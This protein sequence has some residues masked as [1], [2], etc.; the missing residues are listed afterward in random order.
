MFSGLRGVYELDSINATKKKPTLNSIE[1]HLE[2]IE[3]QLQYD[4]DS[5]DLDLILIDRVSD[6]ERQF[7]LKSTQENGHQIFATSIYDPSIMTIG[8][9]WDLYVFHPSTEKR[10]RVRSLDQYIELQAIGIN[11][12]I[13]VVP[14]TTNKGNLSLKIQE[15]EVVTRVEEIRMDEDG[16]MTILG[17][18]MYPDKD[19]TLKDLRLNIQHP[20]EEIK[21]KLQ[22]G[23]R[24]DLTK[25]TQN[26]YQVLGF[27]THIDLNEMESLFHVA[28]ES[29]FK[30][31]YSAL[32]DK[33]E[34]FTGDTLLKLM[35]YQT[36]QSRGIIIKRPNGKQRV[37]L[38]V[39]KKTRNIRIN[40]ASYA[41]KKRIVSKIKRILIQARRHP[42]TKK[43]YKLAFKW[44]GMLPADDKLIMFESF[45]GKQ[46]SCNPR[47]IYEY[48]KEN[49]PGYK[50]YWS[51]DKKYA[52]TFRK[53][54]IPHINRFSLQWLLMTARA[55]YWV[56]N[57]RM[58]LWIPKPK[59]TVYLQTWHG[60]PLKKL[61]ADMEEVHMPGT[62][63]KKYKR[64]FYKESRNWDFLISPNGYST[65]IF[66]RAF[67]FEKDMI[68]SGYPRND[69]LYVDNRDEKIQLLKKEMGLPLDK[70]VILYAPTWRDDQFY[71]KGKYKFDLALDL[72]H[73]RNELGD[74]YIIILRMHYLV[75]ENL[76]LTPY[77]GFAFDYSLYPDIS[78]LYLISDLLI[79]DYSS[80][81]FDYG[82]LKRPMI[83]YVYDIDNYRDKLR[84]F[85]FDFETEAPGPLVK[86]TE[87]VIHSIKDCNN[88]NPVH[89]ESFK[90]FYEKFCYLESGQS[91]KKVVDHVFLRQ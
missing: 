30:L 40:V 21:V 15:K 39:N 44:I 18:A 85:Y 83:F 38:T 71:G 49:E 61:A 62:N 91:S 8:A 89:S 76:D 7:P 59:N 16:K 80:V 42:Q 48:L 52:E 88:N 81:F 66:R 26:R 72:N 3:L 6:E 5:N 75:A 22:N 79:T 86:S 32:R 50:M 77:Q 45:L 54:G 20:N 82:N 46:Y 41:L 2:A 34:D 78:E 28:H 17:Y 65:D 10:E 53:K 11:T 1:L 31:S 35:P 33:D 43:L 57:S 55:K 64:N 67:N 74:E 13:M 9:I 58:P 37:R 68:E 51:V 27:G 69:L 84:G 23:E 25:K 14:Y 47:A 63:T 24:V 19:V 4:C 56:T 70:K 73:L 12:D 87:E 29:L 36:I 90:R 60:T